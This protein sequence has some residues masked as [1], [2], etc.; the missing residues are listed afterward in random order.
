[1]TALSLSAGVAKATP[2]PLGNTAEGPHP[3][4]LR[5]P[6]PWEPLLLEL[7]PLPSPLPPKPLL[8]SPPLLKPA[9][10]A[11]FPEVPVKTRAIADAA[12]AATTASL[13]SLKL[14]LLLAA[15]G[16]T[17]SPPILPPDF[18]LSSCTS[19]PCGG[20][21]EA[22]APPLTALLRAREKAFGKTILRSW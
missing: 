19:V 5:P 12:A 8:A 17:S 21:H 13:K 14:L 22:A 20:A 2:P 6:R 4:P 3:A 1:M 18:S 10:P 15:T 7:L 16:A 11:K 9:P